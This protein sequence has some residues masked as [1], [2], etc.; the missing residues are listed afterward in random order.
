MKTIRLFLLY[1]RN[2]QDIN[3]YYNYALKEGYM[4]DETYGWKQRTIYW[5]HAE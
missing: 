3:S 5:L 1:L 2:R 4:M